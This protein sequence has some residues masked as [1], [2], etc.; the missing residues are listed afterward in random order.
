[1]KQTNKVDMTPQT[2]RKASDCTCYE[3]MRKETIDFLKTQ[4]EKNEFFQIQQEQRKKHS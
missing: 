2:H 1:M 4:K 3:C